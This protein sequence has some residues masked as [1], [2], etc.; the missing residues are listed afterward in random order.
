MEPSQYERDA[1][2]RLAKINETV[3]GDKPSE[4]EQYLTPNTNRRT[5]ASQLSGWLKSSR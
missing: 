5:T 2:I 3:F 4:P 1:S